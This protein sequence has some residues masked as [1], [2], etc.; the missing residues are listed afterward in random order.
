[1]IVLA[2]PVRDFRG[3]WSVGSS[4]FA[5]RA[6]GRVERRLRRDAPANSQDRAQERRAENRA[7]EMALIAGWHAPPEMPPEVN[8]RTGL[9]NT[10][11]TAL[12]RET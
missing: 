3:Q 12:G 7:V 8:H 11:K 2:T 9:P 5:L 10:Q 6:R 1:V 4:W